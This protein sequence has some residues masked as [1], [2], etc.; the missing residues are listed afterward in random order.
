MPVELTELDF[1]NNMVRMCCTESDIEADN[2][3]TYLYTPDIAKIMRYSNLS[4]ILAH[5]D[6]EYLELAS[7]LAV[8]GGRYNAR[9]I[10]LDGAKILVGKSRNPD[11]KLFLQWLRQF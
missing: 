6:D 4:N 5:I 10:P 11:K 3:K 9:W 1:F 8:I 7:E 2:A